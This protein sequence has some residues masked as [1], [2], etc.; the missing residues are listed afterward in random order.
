MIIT[1]LCR[2]DMEGNRSFEKGKKSNLQRAKDSTRPRQKKYKP[3]R[4]YKTRYKS[5]CSFVSVK[6]LKSINTN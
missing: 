1:V 6:P 5:K 4:V 3:L 2:S